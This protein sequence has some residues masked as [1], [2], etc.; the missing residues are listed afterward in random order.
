MTDPVDHYRR[1]HELEA[2]IADAYASAIF[3]PTV[4]LIPF[5]HLDL[6]VQNRDGVL[7]T[8]V[9][10]S[11]EG[12]AIVIPK[13]EELAADKLAC[14][15]HDIDSTY[16]SPG[17]ALAKWPDD[18]A[19]PSETGQYRTKI[20]AFLYFEGGNLIRRAYG[21]KTDLDALI[22]PRVKPKA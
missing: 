2:Q 9:S 22:K 3:S 1:A 8:L 6:A 20:P 4:P 11:C 7:L 17:E 12:C 14:F 21:H 19:E 18:N 10:R 16:W 5:E 15:R 13:L